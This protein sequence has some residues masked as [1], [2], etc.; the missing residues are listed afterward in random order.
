MRHVRLATAFL[1]LGL[2][3]ALAVA[4][5]QAQMEAGTRPPV[6]RLAGFNKRK[7][8]GNG[9][10]MGPDELAKHAVVRTSDLMRLIPGVRVSTRASAAAPVTSTHCTGIGYFVDGVRAQGSNPI[11]VI[12]AEDLLAIEIYK[13]P[14]QIPAQF[15]EK[16]LCA[17]VLLWTRGG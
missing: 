7:A 12:N 1:A 11:D 15:H 9:T 10:F 4:R 6:D 17:A 5:A 14:A 2:L 8:L 16:D 3:S 13:S